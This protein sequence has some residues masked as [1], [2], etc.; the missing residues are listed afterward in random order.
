MKTAQNMQ[1]LALA[2]EHR[3]AGA[4]LRRRV[5]AGDIT[6]ADAVSDDAA[7]VLSVERMLTAQRWVGAQKARDIV[8]MIPCSPGRRVRDLTE[9][10]RDRLVLLAGMTPDERRQLR[11]DETYGVAA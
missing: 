3:L 1:A 6:F 9:R 11:Y 5:N 4:E 7:G 2:N 8:Q 10:Q